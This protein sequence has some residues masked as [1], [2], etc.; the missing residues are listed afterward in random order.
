MSIIG[1]I[2]GLFSGVKNPTFSKSDI[3]AVQQRAE[4]I[5]RAFDASLNAANQ[6]KSRR[7]RENELQCARDGL[8]ELKKL[9]HK[10]PFLQ[11]TNLKA[12][13]ASIISV[14]AE[15]LALPYDDFANTNMTVVSDRASHDSLMM[16]GKDMTSIERHAQGL[17]HLSSSDEQA[18]LMCIQ[19][20]FRVINE[21]IEI[22]RK[23]SNLETKI[24]RL[25]VARNKLKEARKQ[26]NQFA[27]EVDGFDKAEEEITK[28]N[29]AMKAKTQT[30]EENLNDAFEYWNRNREIIG[31]L[32]FNATMQLRTPLRVLEWHGETHSDMRNKPP[33]IVKEMWEG[34]W[35]PK[36]KP[37]RELEIDIDEL[38]DNSMASDIGHVID[39]EYLP[40]L[41]TVRKIVEMPESIDSRIAQLRKMQMPIE[42]ESYVSRHGGIEK[43]IDYFFP[44]FVQTIPKTSA[45]IAGELL[46]LK[47]GTPNRIASTPDAALLAI[48]GIGQAKLNM[49]RDYCAS[50]EGDRDSIRLDK[51][52]K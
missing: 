26:A 7:T 43:I 6:S 23:S 47:L 36:I 4:S 3:L 40:F 37:F 35:A 27:L 41:I 39:S 31:G 30:V 33:H 2:T 29:E 44:L 52:R 13:E 12:V 21:S 11:L 10:F 8:V 45:A 9:A 22:A 46:R 51:V 18:A 32:E 15:T 14:E 34:G 5:L 28:L 19:S 48:K 17:H 24:S 25:D 49:I 20:C 38:P 1:K 42:W 50:I 16:R